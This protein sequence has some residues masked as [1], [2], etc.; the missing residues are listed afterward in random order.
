M[1]LSAASITADELTPQRLYLLHF[2]NSPIEQLTEFYAEITGTNILLE[3]NSYPLITLVAQQRLNK[4]DTL[5]LI[6]AYLIEQGIALVPIDDHTV[7]AI[8]RSRR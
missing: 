5:K 6:H 3:G 1:G 2:R 8:M 4:S 7:K